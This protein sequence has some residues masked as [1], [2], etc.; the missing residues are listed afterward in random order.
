M[1]MA[2]IDPNTLADS[3]PN[4]IRELFLQLERMHGRLNSN[5][6]LALN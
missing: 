4:L 5:F 6:I 3:T 2:D 1:T